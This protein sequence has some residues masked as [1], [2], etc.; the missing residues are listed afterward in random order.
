[1]ELVKLTFQRQQQ[2]REAVLPLLVLLELVALL[3]RL[4]STPLL[5]L[6][7]ALDQK[8]LA[9]RPLTTPED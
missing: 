5:Q 3:L 9:A 6:R 8:Q 7:A 4:E 2:L 1:V